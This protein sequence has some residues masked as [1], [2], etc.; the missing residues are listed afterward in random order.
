M[1]AGWVLR[2]VELYLNNS[3]AFNSSFLGVVGIGGFRQF[4]YSTY[5]LIPQGGY[6]FFKVFN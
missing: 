4:Y 2:W 1:K 5:V 3:N 6:G